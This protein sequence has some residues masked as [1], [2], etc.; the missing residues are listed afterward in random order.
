MNQVISLT[1]KDYFRIGHPFIQTRHL[2]NADF[3]V[4]GPDL[5]KAQQATL[6]RHNMRYRPLDATEF[7]TKMQYLKFQLLRSHLE[8]ADKDAGVSFLDFDTFFFRD[9]AEI[10]KEPFHM[11]VTVRNSF[12]RRRGPLR[13]LSNGGVIFTRQGE[14]TLQLCD[15]AMET[16]KQGKHAS[17]PE[18]DRIF[19]ELESKNRPEEKRWSR[20]NLRWWVDQVFL[21]CLVLR[22]G[23]IQIKNK[24]FYDFDSY[25]IGLFNCDIYNRL[26]PRP[27]QLKK[28]KDKAYIIHMKDSGRRR[29]KNF[30][31]LLGSLL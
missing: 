14:L 29:V 8:T 16:M 13:A 3:T 23:L 28:L 10:F 24:S 31:K 5:T 21:S 6:T 2:I 27:H 30:E 26:D 4:Y 1:D 17:I 18:Y 12:V 9:W 20:K 11:G 22:H 7:T 25:R 15:L 19:N